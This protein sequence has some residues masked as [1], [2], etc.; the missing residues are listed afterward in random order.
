MGPELR[1]LRVW[2]LGSLEE[3]VY[4]LADLTAPEWKGIAP[5]LARD[6]RIY[7]PLGRGDRFMRLTLPE[8]PTG[9]ISAEPV[10]SGGWFGW[11]QNP[12]GR[13]LPVHASQKQVWSF[14]FEQLLL[15]DLETGTTRRITT[16]GTRLG[17]FDA[18]D[19]T[20]RILVTGDL[21]GVVRAGPITG[22]EP[23]LLLGH[24]GMITGLA[25]SPDGRWIA[26][27]S[28]ESVRLWPMP[29]V[30]RPPLHTLPH[31]ELLA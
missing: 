20:G 22:E 7:A 27:A 23:H 19:P 25:I 10:L 26:S 6:G 8:E 5:R 24:Q 12:V 29:D 18:I 17:Q 30:T 16:H 9:E 1:A 21:D 11:F 3:R 15:Y 28:D 31:D 4:S 14:E 2:D 13:F